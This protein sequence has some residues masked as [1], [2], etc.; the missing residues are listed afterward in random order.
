[1]KKLYRWMIAGLL[2]ALPGTGMA[3]DSQT[4]L[5]DPAR[6]RVISAGE[7]EVVYADVQTLFGQQTMDY[8]GSIE[9]LKFTMYVESYKEK[10][11]AFD[12]ERDQLVTEIREFRVEL[13]ANKR[14]KVYEMKKSLAGT[15]DSKGERKLPESFR[16]A[17]R[18]DADAEELY[19]NLY[20]L[21]RAL[22]V[23]PV[24]ASDF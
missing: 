10:A 7:D 22:P 13:H 6:Y 21:E 5:A 15:Y 24:P 8:P 3:M 20:R 16:K 11:D 4:L 1:M 18:I 23:A 12:F 2:L 14:E 19:I 9:N 17:Y